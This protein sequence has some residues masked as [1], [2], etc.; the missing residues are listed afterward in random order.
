MPALIRR[1]IAAAT[2]AAAASASLAAQTLS[3]AEQRIVAI[4]RALARE[5]S[6]D[7]YNALALAF[8]RRARE[9]ADGAF[10]DRA[11][12]AI[13]AS[14]RLAPENLEALKMRA[15]VL[16][17]RHEFGRALELSQTLHKR[18][19]DDLLIYGFLT[20]AHAELGNYADAEEACQ[21]MLDLRPGTVPALTRAAFLREMFGDVEGAIDFMSKAY[22]RTPPT[23]TEDRAW[24][25]THLGHLALIEGRTGEAEGVITRALAIFPGYHYA[26]ANLAKVRTAQNRHDDAVQLLR[27]RY[28]AAPHPENL[29]A[30]AE[31]LDR[32]GRVTEARAAFEEFETKARKEMDGADNAN[33]ELVLY[34]AD[35]ARRP[36]E[37]LRVARL[38]IA[39]RRDVYTLDAY[40]WALHASGQTAEA[41]TQIERALAVGVRDPVILAHARSIR[42]GSTSAP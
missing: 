39:R 14:L 22:E 5:K 40:A 1:V 27:R 17:G 16:L 18:N 33:R 26:L 20:D 21:W 15:W 36:E 19:A 8:A 37:A 9:T 32:A 29:F 38:E 13:E 31:A 4:E 3:P 10:Y 34:Y 35:H 11:D 2:V 28:D 23:E 41:R 25:L 42:G 30:L 7:G 24:I 12:E 6:A